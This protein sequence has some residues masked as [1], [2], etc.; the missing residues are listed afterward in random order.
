[1]TKMLEN[2]RKMV[3]RRTLGRCKIKLEVMKS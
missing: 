2:I 3:Q 1:M